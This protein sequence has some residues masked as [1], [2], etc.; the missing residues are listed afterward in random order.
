[1]TVVV[2]DTNVLI[3]GLFWKGIPR[4]VIHFARQGDVQAVTCQILLDELKDVLT[5]PNK[6]FQLSEQ[7]AD[8]VLDDILTF[9]QV[10]VPADIP[11]VCRDPND[12]VVLACALAADAKYIVTGDPDLLTLKEHE[13]ISIVT[14]RVFFDTVQTLQSRLQ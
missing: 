10:I 8:L 12:N 7:E 11:Q 13:Q 4:Q 9:S 5:R 3:S 14:A 2:Y 1:V 6:P